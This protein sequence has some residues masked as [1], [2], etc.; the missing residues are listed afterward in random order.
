MSQTTTLC[1]FLENTGAE[2]R[3][4]DMG[5]RVCEISRDDFLRF[6][7][8]E[9]AYPLPMQQKAWFALVQLR[10]HV[11]KEPLIWFLC[12]DLDEQ[13]KLV[14]ATRD[15]FIHRFVELASDNKQETDLDAALQD[16]PFTF[17]PREDKLANLN[18]VVNRDLGMPASQYF[19]HAKDY[20]GG[21][22]GWEQWNFI[23]YQGIADLA[24]RKSDPHICRLLSEAIEHLP[25]EPLH[26]LCQCLEN[27]QVGEL[28]GNAL[29]VRLAR[30]LSSESPSPAL[31]AAL[32]R[33]LSRAEPERIGEA[34]RE[35]LAH[36]AATNPEILAAVG[37]RAWEALLQ[38]PVARAYLER[39]ASEDVP[40]DV[41]NHCL[42][43]LL[44]QPALQ[45]QILAELRAEDRPEAVARAFQKMLGTQ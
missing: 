21:K 3:I 40:Q 34:T 24:A 31:L 19:D 43:D 18:A 16:N 11:S 41:F 15:Y 45:A 32:L 38:K 27:H 42:G 33:G 44:R 36:P 39:L 6:E 25:D 12:F 35:V 29:Q 23:G 14:L 1:E 4:Y 28:L 5:R 26:A 30:A 10:P 37:G 17:K 20:F 22:L 7:R 8:T 13:G 2:L 9:T